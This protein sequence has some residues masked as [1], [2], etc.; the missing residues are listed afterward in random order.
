MMSHVANERHRNSQKKLQFQ[1]EILKTIFH[2]YLLPST[3][4]LKIMDYTTFCCQIFNCM[5]SSFCR[6]SI[7]E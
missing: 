3:K 6:I 7:E 4:F 1:Q 5:Q 2:A